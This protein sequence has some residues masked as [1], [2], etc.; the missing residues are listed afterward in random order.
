MPQGERAKRFFGITVLGDLVLS[1]GI[2]RVLDNLT[3]VAGATA[4]ATNPTVTT[5]A[6]T[7]MVATVPTTAATTT[8]TTTA[9]AT[10]T[11]TKVIY[12]SNTSVSQFAA[13]LLKAFR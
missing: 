13:R 10:T 8:A 7:T 1:E 3:E 11:T 2:D 5:E 4:V 12:A 9:A 6:P